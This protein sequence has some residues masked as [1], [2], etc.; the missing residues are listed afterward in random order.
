MSVVTTQG[1]LG[2]G[3]T[4]DAIKQNLDEVPEIN[5]YICDNAESCIE[6]CP[7]SLPHLPVELRTDFVF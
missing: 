1:T 5:L 3:M 4:H 2:S 6:N 7:H